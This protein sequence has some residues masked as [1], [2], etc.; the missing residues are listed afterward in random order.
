MQ[1]NTGIAPALHVQTLTY[2]DPV[3]TLIIPDRSRS[4]V[5]CPIT[6]ADLLGRPKN[7]GGGD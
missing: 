4:S 7:V 6:P 2:S 5:L 1:N 3:I